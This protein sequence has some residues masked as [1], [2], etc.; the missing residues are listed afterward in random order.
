MEPTGAAGQTTPWNLPSSMAAWSNSIW[1][2]TAG[3]VHYSKRNEWKRIE[4][5]LEL[6]QDLNHPGEQIMVLAEETHTKWNG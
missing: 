1:T 5:W 3:N 2:L 6:I 4:K